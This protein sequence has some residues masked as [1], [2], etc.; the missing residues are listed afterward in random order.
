MLLSAESV[1][2][3]VTGSVTA[4]V[5]VLGTLIAAWRFA[6]QGSLGNHYEVSTTPCRVRT[7]NNAAGRTFVYTLH[8]TITNRS[9]AIQTIHARWRRLLLP[10]ETTGEYDPDSALDLYTDEAA[11]LRLG[12]SQGSY[13][14]LPGEI[15]EDHVVRISSVAQE[16]CFLEYAYRYR[17]WGTV[18]CV[19]PWRKRRY[20]SK[21]LVVPVDREDLN[22]LANQPKEEARESTSQEQALSSADKTASA[23]AGQEGRSPE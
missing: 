20:E 10:Y 3:V 5:L 4:G 14:L 12:K 6:L 17:R 1:T 8:F 23:S 7:G 21:I 13:Q 16:V 18:W 9:A 15:C 22:A 19:L 11:V 2:N